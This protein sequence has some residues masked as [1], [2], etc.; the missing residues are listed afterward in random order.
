MRVFISHSSIDK[1]AVEELALALEERGIDPW[2]DKFRI[3]AGDDVVASINAGLEEADGGLIVFSAHSKDSQWVKAE[4]SYLTWAHVEE[5]KVLIPVVIGDDVDIPPLLRP[6]ARRGIEEI[7]AIVDALLNRKPRPSVHRNPALGRVETVR[8][9]L[10][11]D[12]SGAIRVDVRIGTETYGHTTREGLSE[13]LLSAMGEYLNGFRYAGALRSPAAARAAMEESLLQLGRELRDLCLPGDCGAALATL[14]DGSPIGTTI[15]ICFETAD[16]ELL[17]L[18]FEALRLGDDRLLTIQD[19]V[20]ILRRPAGMDVSEQP[21]MA[22]PLKIL[23]AVGAPDEGETSSAVLDQ[24]RELQSILDAVEE[25]QR[26]GNVEVRILEVGN[27]EVIGDAIAR[28]AYHVLHLSC[29]GMPGKLEL[30]D[31]EGRAVSVTAEDLIRPIREAGRPLPLV[32]LNSCHGGATSPGGPTSLAMSLLRAGV[33]AVVAMQTS[34]TDRYATLLARAFYEALAKRPLAS[35]ALAAAR[36]EIERER[37]ANQDDPAPPEY[38]TASLFVAGEERRIADF[39]LVKEPLSMRPVYSV[40]GP[41]PQLRIDDLIGRR[42]ELRRTLRTLRNASHAGVVLTGIGGVGK[43]AI[44]GRAMQRL[45]EEGWAV[46]AHVGKF[47][48]A[49]I[50]MTIGVA[51]MQRNSGLAALLR[52]RQT[53]DVTRL[54]LI[55]KAVAE[56]AVILVLDDFEQNLTRGGDAFLDPDLAEYFAQLAMQARRGRLLITCRHPVPGDVR[57]SFDH[58]PVGPLS[59]AETRKLLQRLPALQAQDPT[60]VATILRM[61]GGH[62]RMLE[63]L[64]ALLRGGKGKGRLLNVNQKLSALLANSGIDTKATLGNLEEAIRAA[65]HLGMRDVFLAELLD[66]V[67]EE[68]IDEALLQ[69]AVSNLPVTAEGLA[70]MFTGD[71]GDVAAAESE[72]ARLADLSLVYRDDDGVA[73]VHRWTAE[74]LKALSDHDA[75]K[76]KAKKAALYRIWKANEEQELV[77]AMEAVRNFLD[78]EDHDSAARAAVDCVQALRKLHQTAVAAAFA[79]EVLAVLP[80]EQEGFKALTDE[81]AKALTDLGQPR[82]ALSRYVRLLERHQTAARDSHDSRKLTD[83]ALSHL[84]V[85]EMHRGFGDIEKAEQHF[86][87]ALSVIESVVGTSAEDDDLQFHLATALEK[88]GDV[89]HQRREHERARDHY[90]RDLSI[91]RQLSR[92]PSARWEYRRNL[93]VALNK[94]GNV[95]QVLGQLKD[96]LN[97]YLEALQIRETLASGKPDPVSQRDLSISYARIGG[98]YRLMGQVVLAREYLARNLEAAEGLFAAEPERLDYQLDLANALLRVGAEDRSDTRLRRSLSILR[99]LRASG[100]L[101]PRDAEKIPFIENLLQKRSR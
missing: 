62:P 101:P 23:V 96:A 95:Q 69:L 16:A 73:F 32:L 52:D 12:A 22:G 91:L 45:T 87:D 78:G 40:A 74:G 14:V 13:E 81:E 24:E 68:G 15:E 1:P 89:H 8:V 35:W 59:N 39:G 100:T 50:A 6:F 49:R 36:R 17:A 57:S 90:L 38:A 66:L 54:Q 58:V 21:A 2:V 28:D 93:P 37:L 82:R 75:W 60:S 71:E 72:I 9:G 18:P 55:G 61:V 83:L 53:D 34:V 41:V 25:A 29:H 4:I 67:R 79:S 7:D 65:L 47:D 64:D 43:S 11:G 51:L 86:R 5:G 27:P 26:S 10:D 20:V 3:G 63:F 19:R 33:P 30:E 46:A 85:G 92:R 76:A 99:L 77:E 88:L 70:R 94:L 98:V 48:V 84:K 56:E 42:K 44:A 31:E 97:S 80:E